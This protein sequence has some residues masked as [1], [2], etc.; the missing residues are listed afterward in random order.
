MKRQGAAEPLVVASLCSGYNAP[1]LALERLEV[2]FTEPFAA[3]KDKNVVKVLE[4]NFSSLQ[5]I[6]GDIMETPIQKLNQQ[7]PTTGLNLLTAG[8]P[9]QPFSSQGQGQTPG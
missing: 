8:F 7:L 1:A 5:H 3:D 4:H 6:F 9:C 2:S